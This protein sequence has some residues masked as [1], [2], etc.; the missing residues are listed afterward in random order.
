M[1]YTKTEAPAK[2]R[3]T[4]GAESATINLRQLTVLPNAKLMLKY[5]LD[6]PTVH[7][8]CHFLAICL[9][10]TMQQQTITWLI[11]EPQGKTGFGDAKIADA[12]SI[13]WRFL[14]LREFAN[15]RAVII[16]AFPSCA[17]LWF[18]EHAVMIQETQ[19][20]QHNSTEFWLPFVRSLMSPKTLVRINSTTTRAINFN[21]S[22]VPIETRVAAWAAKQSSLR[23]ARVRAEQLPR[24]CK[25]Q[26]HLTITKT[27]KK[28]RLVL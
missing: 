14:L 4:R 3:A 24:P 10:F 20:W 18:W 6:I 19:L 1:L 11:I 22:Y 23:V 12:L 21:M 15:L 8:N 27:K 26:I 28:H 25:Q 2:N 5:I 13:L 7:S 16:T 17:Q 9:C